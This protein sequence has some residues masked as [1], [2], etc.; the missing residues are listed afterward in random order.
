MTTASIN[1]AKGKPAKG[2]AWSTEMPLSCVSRIA[3]NAPLLDRILRHS[4]N[5]LASATVL[6]TGSLTVAQEHGTT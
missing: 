1:H 6:Y 3:I 5:A 4:M 2:A